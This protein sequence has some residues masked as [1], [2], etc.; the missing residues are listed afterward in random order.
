MLQKILLTIM[1]VVVAQ[2]IMAET[3]SDCES[4]EDIIKMNSCAENTYMAAKK[5]LNDKVKDIKAQDDIDYRSKKLLDKA[6]KSWQGF[7]WNYCTFV[8]VAMEGEVGH[9]FHKFDCL[10]RI[11][12]Q[13]I[14]NLQEYIE[15]LDV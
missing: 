13:Q 7:R 14:E 15:G 1:L 8:T 10:G 5:K 4:T 11:T 9:F 6:Q 12:K 3:I 2:G